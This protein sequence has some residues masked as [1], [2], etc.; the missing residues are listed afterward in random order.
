VKTSRI[1][2][3]LGILALGSSLPLAAQAQETPAA[4]TAAPATTP[5]ETAPQQS[6][7]DAR[8]ARDEF[9]AG[10]E[11]YE[12]GR[13]Q[14]AIHS[15]QVAGSLVPSADLWFNIGSAYEQMARARGEVSDY[16]LAV[17]NYRRYLT[18]RVD[19][20]DRAAVEANITALEERLEAARSALRERATTGELRLRSTFEGAAV[21]V[22]AEPAG[23]TPLETQQQL[24]SGTHRVDATREG[25]LPYAAQV[26]IERG[27]GATALIALEPA[28]THR[29][30]TGDPVFAWVSWGLG[31]L[32]LAGSI[33]LG[34][35][36]QGLVPAEY[37]EAALG[38]ARTMGAFSDA[39]LAG[40]A[41]FAV[42]GIALYFIESNAVGMVTERGG[43]VEE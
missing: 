16:E 34:I 19:P 25:Y 8:R 17:A 40:A 22:D 13:Y 7:E 42:I 2:P 27:L 36:A 21:T 15:F 6:A 28:R 24:P 5:T 43:V 26:G 38:D 12:A 23:T 37:N 29:A 32:S 31:A 35:A 1:L 14:E 9:R 4:T 3:A 18:E 41:G 39:C 33:G 30:I 11:H 10:V 20:P